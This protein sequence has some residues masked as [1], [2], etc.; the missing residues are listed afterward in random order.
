MIFKN[1]TFSKV[2]CDQ[3]CPGLGMGK[4]NLRHEAECV[5]TI[6]LPE[7]ECQRSDFLFRVTEKSRAGF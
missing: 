7:I 3:K 4:G 6:R 5:R 1:S 2:C